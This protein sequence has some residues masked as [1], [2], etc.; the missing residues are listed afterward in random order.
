MTKH[1][2]VRAPED[3]ELF[4]IR[5]EEGS[6]PPL[7]EYTFESVK[8]LAMRFDVSVSTIENLIRK[9][10]PTRHRVYE[11]SIRYRVMDIVRL[12]D[13]NLINQRRLVPK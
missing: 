1:A 7:D 6:R 12:I 5:I 8:S 10:K 3:S 13:Q 9:H 4:D 11:G 2:R